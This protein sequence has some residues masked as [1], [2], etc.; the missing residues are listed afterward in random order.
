[1]VGTFSRDSKQCCKCNYY[2]DCDEKRMEL[3]AYLVLCEMEPPIKEQYYTVSLSDC[4][5][6]I[7]NEETIRQKAE[8]E[9][10]KELYKQLYCKFRRE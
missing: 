3:C 8:K 1:M 9:F 7:I 4:I 5:Q 2:K 6:N 10:E